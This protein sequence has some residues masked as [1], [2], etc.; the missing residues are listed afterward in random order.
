MK[1][2]VTIVVLLG[3][4]F[5]LLTLT[6]CDEKSSSSQALPQSQTT[7]GLG[8]PQDYF[9]TDIGTRWTYVITIAGSG[10][11]RDDDPLEHKVV[12]WPIAE[13][14]QVMESRGILYRGSESN[15]PLKLIL[16]VKAR[17]PKQG[18]LEYPEGYE[19][20]VERDDLGIY[21]YVEHIYWAIS[22]SG[23]YS[24]NEIVMFSPNSPGA[25]SGGLWGSYGQEM[26]CWM[27]VKFFGDKPGTGIGLSEENDSLVFLGPERVGDIMCL[28]FERRVEGS[29]VDH[30]EKASYL[31]SGFSEDMWYAKGIGLVKLVQ[32]VNGKTTMT[33]TLE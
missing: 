12:R 9:L 5:A 7:F 26:G 33:W 25:P 27:R 11:A 14:A 4:L 2:M 8:S 23:R 10:E 6:A 20:V 31:D 32:K 29:E 3:G 15:T 19:I 13:G 17:A 24:V 28:H 18:P 16:S 30:G 21:E 1:Y 22:R